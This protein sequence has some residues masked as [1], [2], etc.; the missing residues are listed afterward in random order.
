MHIA[1]SASKSA[2]VDPVISGA[3][4]ISPNSAAVAAHCNAL[5]ACGRAAMIASAVPTTKM[6][7]F[8]RASG[9]QVRGSRSE[10]RGAALAPRTSHPAPRAK[11]ASSVAF[12]TQQAGRSNDKDQD[13]DG[14]DD[15]VSLLEQVGS[16]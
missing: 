11:R 7:R 15:H 10:V 8:K 12:A 6:A 5:P 1:V 9:A 16:A 2:A 4:S 13:Q 3:A 14:E